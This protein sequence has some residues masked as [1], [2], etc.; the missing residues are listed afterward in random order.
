[1]VYS[2]NT[3]SKS[4]NQ[5]DIYHINKRKDNHMIISAD[6]EKALKTQHRFMINTL[7][8]VSSEGTYL[9]FIKD[10]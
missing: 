9:N 1:M 3:V 10:I 4:A 6:D 8:K 7:K 5:C 2:R